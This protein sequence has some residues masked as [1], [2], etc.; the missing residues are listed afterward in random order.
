MA[1]AFFILLLAALA[2]LSGIGALVFFVGR[3]VARHLRQNPESARRLADL[4]LP[5]LGVKEPPKPDAG[6]EVKRT[7]GTLL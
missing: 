7:K 4:L 5:M 2:V 3:H 1:F 6:P